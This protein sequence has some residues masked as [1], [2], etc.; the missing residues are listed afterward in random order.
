MLI[1]GAISVKAALSNHKR[2]VKKVFIDQEKKT[3]DFNY[4]RKLAKQ[5]N[6]ELIEMP[7]AYLS[8][9]AI[10][11]TYGG[12]LAEA[13]QRC[14]DELVDGDVFYLDG[15][16]DPF[17]L[18][19]IM[20]NLY[21]FGIKNLILSKKDYSNMEYQLLKSSAGAYDMLNIKF[22]DDVLSIVQSLKKDN[23]KIYALMRSDKALDIFKTQFVTKSLFMIG[24][25]KR[26]I[27]ANLLQ[28]ADNDLFIP[29]GSDFRNALN[30]SNAASV[31]ATLLFAQ[32]KK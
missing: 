15:I 16:E 12:V 14:S 5:E 9:M 4:I 30:A 27:A 7:S 13:G 8:S 6:V 32:R 10:G 29:Y 22:S 17:N 1:E 18:G 2:E 31:V 24:G 20:R 21:A 28:E 19:Y 26:G 3:K 23:Y 25:E 11:K